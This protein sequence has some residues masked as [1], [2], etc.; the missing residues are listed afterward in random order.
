M[1]VVT[2]HL[3]SSHLVTYHCRPKSVGTDTE[4]TQTELNFH[5]YFTQVQLYQ[6]HTFLWA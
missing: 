3:V 6:S 2:A 4:L 1:S 5:L